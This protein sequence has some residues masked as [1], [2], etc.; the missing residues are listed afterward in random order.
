MWYCTGNPRGR[1]RGINLRKGSSTSVG[2]RAV[3]SG[4]EGLYGRPRPV[5]L[6]DILE[7]HDHLPTPRATIKGHKCY[8]QPHIILPRPYG[9][10]GP[11]PSTV[12]VPPGICGI[13]WG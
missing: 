5:P 9:S 7:K 11:L 13:E 10:F 3:G 2:A 1:P 4:R 6:A 12:N 8:S